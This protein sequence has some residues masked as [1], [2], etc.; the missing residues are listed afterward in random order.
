MSW[1][2][3]DT[4]TG[5]YLAARN[6]ATSSVH[7]D[8]FARNQG[9]VRAIV[10]GPNHL[11]FVSTLIEQELGPAWRERGRL[12]A[13]FVAPVYD[14]DRVR[15]VLTVHG[16]GETFA[17]DVT[18]EN[19]DAKVV[20]TGAAAWT[21]PDAEETL[22]PAVS[23]SPDE[24][25]RD[26][27][28][29]RDGERVPTEEVLATREEVARFCTLYHDHL[30]APDRVPTTYLSP[31]LLIPARRFMYD[32]GVSPGM[33]GEIDIRQYRPLRP[34]TPYRYE[35]VVRSRRTR[36]SLEIVDFLFSTHD[37]DGALMCAISHTHLIPHRDLPS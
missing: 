36:G 1:N 21:P 19:G 16:T 27:R 28:A 35:G 2:S 15:A 12:R 20:V 29:L 22:P 33:W 3:G 23:S 10:A 37:R 25:L 17:A 24:E 18:S 5:P 8:E 31:L 30:D 11:A 26:L 7:S 14:G 32:R 9:F 13:R 4:I 6:N 34:D